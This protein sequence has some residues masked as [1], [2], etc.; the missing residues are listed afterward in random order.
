[1]IEENDLTKPIFQEEKKQFLEIAIYFCL[2][3]SNDDVSS[4]L[5][6]ELA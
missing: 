4:A 6:N 1:M 2:H 5:I 3:S